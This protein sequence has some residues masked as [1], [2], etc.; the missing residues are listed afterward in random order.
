MV[1][2]SILLSVF[3]AGFCIATSV[4]NV[5]SIVGVPLG[6]AEIVGLPENDGSSPD[7]VFLGVVKALRAGELTALYFHFETNYLKSLTGLAGVQD[8]PAEDIDSF[9]TVMLDPCLSNIVI[10]A[11]SASCNGQCAT[12]EAALQENFAGRT[13]L[14]DVKLTLKHDSSGWKIISYDDDNW[15]D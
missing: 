12:V 6:S 11:Y 14:D 10:T 15:D 13:L 4:T 1:K 8:I 5:Q 7:T 2:N 9:R 3:L